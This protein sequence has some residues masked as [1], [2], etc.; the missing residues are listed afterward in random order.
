MKTAGRPGVAVILFTFG[1]VIACAVNS[2]SKFPN[3][4]RGA[5]GPGTM[6]P[7][8]VREG[9]TSAPRAALDVGVDV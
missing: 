3:W 9:V 1:S 5:A 8:R 2:R 6:G 4:S 7:R